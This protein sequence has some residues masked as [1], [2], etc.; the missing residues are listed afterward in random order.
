[1]IMD[2]VSARFDTFLASVLDTDGPDGVVDCFKFLFGAFVITK[3]GSVIGANDAFVKMIQYP[4]PELYGMSALDLIAEDERAAMVARFAE[5]NTDHYEL[6]LLLKNQQLLDV[7]VAPRIF[8]AKGEIYRLAEFIDNGIQKK[9]ETRLKESEEKFHSVFEQAAVGIARVA[10]NGIFLEVNQ[11]LCD[12]LGYSREELLQ[13]T[14]QQITHPDDLEADLE[15]VQQMLQNKRKTYSMEKRY[16]H[17]NGQ[18]IWI[19][20]TVSLIRSAEGEAKY[21]VAIIEDIN[22]RK[23]MERELNDRATHDSLTGLLNRT[24]LN[25]ALEKEMARATRYGRPYSLMMIDIDH[26]KLVNDNYGHQAGDKVLME[27]AQIL[28]L[29]TRT[30][31][32][33]GRFGGEEF[34]VMLPELDHEQALLLAERIR[35][36]VE[37]HVIRNQ[38]RT[39]NVTVSIGVASYP[40]HGDDVEKLVRASDNAMYKAK[41]DGRNRI[42]SATP[43]NPEKPA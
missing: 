25:N 33:V 17:K 12:T 13:K 31:D 3:E 22:F 18:T 19:S 21:F 8:Y 23:E 7:L 27:L 32:V 1:M 30:A 5:G 38:D 29:A 20:L 2:S 43:E 4:R 28:G 42:A 35:R 24:E 41:S 9:I 37:A 15:L 10:P 14:F 36:A 40:E 34:L 26:F 6:K 39:I 11:K 16:F